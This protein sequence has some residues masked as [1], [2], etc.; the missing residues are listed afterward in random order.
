MKLFLA[1]DF[2][3]PDFVPKYLSDPFI[4][5]L[6]GLFLS[7]F[8]TLSLF[9]FQFIKKCPF[10]HTG[11][12]L[13]LLVFP[14]KR[15][16]CSWSISEFTL[17]ES[18]SSVGYPAAAWLLHRGFC[19]AIPWITRAVL[20][21]SRAL[22]L[23]FYF[24]TSS[25]SWASRPCAS[26]SLRCHQWLCLSVLLS[27]WTVSPT[28]QHSQTASLTLALEICHHAVQPWAVCMKPHWPH[29]S[30]LNSWDHP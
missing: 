10:R 25:K 14:H 29:S 2:D 24:Q 18:S 6:C 19:L 26:C 4:F 17:K 9:V 5:F 12:V 8:Q 16:S 3:F 13:K 11:L 1:L 7:L 30:C 15:M 21:K 28:E 22:A 20:C 23:Q 27:L